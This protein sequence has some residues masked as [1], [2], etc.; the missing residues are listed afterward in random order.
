[1]NDPRVEQ[2]LVALET[3]LT[4]QEQALAEMSD[5]LAAARLESARSSELLQQAL[6]D[7]RQ[8]RTLLYAD[9]ADEP[10]PPHW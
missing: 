5:A 7:L 6:D 4:F 2:R 8:L 9:P 10:P 1:V 3:R